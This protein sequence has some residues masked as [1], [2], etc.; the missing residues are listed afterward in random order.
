MPPNDVAR[1]HRQA[2]AAAMRRH[3]D[4]LKARR[5]ELRAEP[6][7]ARTDLAR[8]RLTVS[9]ETADALRRLRDDATAYLDAADRP[10]RAVFPELFTAA[11]IELT[12]RLR[13]RLTDLGLPGPDRIRTVRPL[14][15]NS[16]RRA[17]VEDRLTL[18]VG[19]SGGIG[20]GRLLLALMPGDG[21]IIAV[22]LAVGVGVAAAGWLARTR[23]AVAE[24][25]RLRRWASET[26]ADLRAGFEATLSER[27]LEAEGRL[28]RE[29][30]ARQAELDAALCEHQLV[31]RR[32]AA[33]TPAGRFGNRG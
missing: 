18:L 4:E 24:R 7:R 23:R 13:A 11:T 14:V 2:V 5:E 19:A 20:L 17:T 25:T 27:L 15:I 3:S 31:A 10:A 16:G 22:S 6:S 28:N 9:T 21:G 26:L 12:V 8:L 33:Q 30:R 32:L 1:R 29:L